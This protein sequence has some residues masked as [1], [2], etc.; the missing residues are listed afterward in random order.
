MCVCVARTAN[1]SMQAA[2]VSEEFNLNSFH[3][4]TN[5]HTLFEK[6]HKDILAAFCPILYY[7]WLDL[8]GTF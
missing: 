4:H 6:S 7:C 1:T 2:D 3:T 8:T 5:G